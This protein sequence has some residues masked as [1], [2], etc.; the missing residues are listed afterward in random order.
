MNTIVELQGLWKGIVCLL[1]SWF[2][3]MAEQLKGIVL[4]ISQTNP[5]IWVFLFLILE[6]RAFDLLHFGVGSSLLFCVLKFNFSIS[7][8]G[9]LCFLK[10]D[11]LV[12]HM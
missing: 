7:S 6:F 8:F 4:L 12:M 9:F 3:Q 10:F 5:I 11:M 1:L 2:T